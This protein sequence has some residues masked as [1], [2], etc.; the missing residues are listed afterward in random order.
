MSANAT[1]RVQFTLRA[2]E[3]LRAI[4]R[5]NPKSNTTSTDAFVP[6]RVEQGGGIDK[7]AAANPYRPPRVEG[8]LEGQEPLML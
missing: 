8:G 4:S 2:D 5:M 7:G 1:W 6:I 3:D